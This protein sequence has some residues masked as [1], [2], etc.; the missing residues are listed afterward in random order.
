[1]Q[2]LPEGPLPIEHKSGGYRPGGPADVQ[3]AAQVL[4]LREMFDVDVSHGVVFSGRDRRRHD[5]TVDPTL[6]AKAHKAAES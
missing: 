5:I 2:F 4:C 3:V 1:V 6:A